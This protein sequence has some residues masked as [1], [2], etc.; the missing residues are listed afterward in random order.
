MSAPKKSNEQLMELGRML[1]EFYDAGYVN[2]NRALVF[3]FLKGMASGLGAF[4]G[5]TIV[6]VLL[7][8]ILS[9]FDQLPFLGPIAESIN[10]A[11]TR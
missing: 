5:G 9:L 4:L 3:S 8:W 1:Q 2:R 10:E 11:L 7:L 6:I